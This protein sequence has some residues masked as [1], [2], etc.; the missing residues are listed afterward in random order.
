MTSIDNDDKLFSTLVCG[1]TNETS[2]LSA[3]LKNMSIPIDHYFNLI[4][5]YRDANIDSKDMTFL[6]PFC[7]RALLEA[8]LTVLLGRID[9]F[10][11]LVI[12]K[13]QSSQSYDLHK[14]NE[15]AIAWNKD[16][17]TDNKPN[18]KI[19]TDPLKIEQISRSLFSPYVDE[20]F[21][22]PSA[23]QLIDL[24]GT[25]P[26]VPTILSIVKETEP[27]NFIKK[28]KGIATSVY[29]TLSK[30]THAEFVVPIHSVCDQTTINDKFDQLLK[31]IVCLA[32]ASHFIETAQSRLSFERSFELAKK[33]Q[34]KIPC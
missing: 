16:I 23:T 9:P 22:K 30:G 31:V 3:I 20:I 17:L 32:M 27:E 24:L 29:S 26:E 5:S 10:R 12:S 18:P 14:R 6:G 13:F 25:L 7:G 4:L 2:Q 19:W 8:S 1:E 28:I 11:I 21:W 34:E 15:I 33:I